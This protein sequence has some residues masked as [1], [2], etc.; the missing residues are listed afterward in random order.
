MNNN[1][2]FFNICDKLAVV[3]HSPATA[4][5]VKGRGSRAMDN[6]LTHRNRHR[7]FWSNF[8]RRQ[9]PDV[10]SYRTTALCMATCRV[11]GQE[12]AEAIVGMEAAILDGMVVGN[13]PGE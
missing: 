8:F 5:L 11:I 13:E 7:H 4:L 1:K 10:G 3:T 9:Q 12:S 6:P 2:T